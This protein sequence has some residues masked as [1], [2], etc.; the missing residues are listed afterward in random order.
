MNTTIWLAA[1]FAASQGFPDNCRLPAESCKVDT[2]KPLT[3]FGRES[4]RKQRRNRKP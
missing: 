1:V 4:K 3:T 2:S